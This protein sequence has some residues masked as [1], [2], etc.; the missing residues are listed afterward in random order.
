M[1]GW[2]DGWVGDG[3]SKRDE[4]RFKKDAIFPNSSILVHEC[5]YG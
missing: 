1:D 4:L 3:N 5:L 2:M